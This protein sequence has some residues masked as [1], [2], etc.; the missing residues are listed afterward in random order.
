MEI[1]DVVR[2]AKKEGVQ[3]VEFLYVDNSG[4]ARGKVTHVDHLK[5]RM[6]S[7]IGLTPA[8]M[9]MNVFDHL[10]PIPEMTAVGEVRLMPDP[11]SFRVLPYHPKV[12]AVMCDQ[13]SL[14]HE[15]WAAC[16][17]SFLK[18]IIRQAENMGIT[19]RATYE[20]EFTLARLNEE[21]KH[22]PI[23]ESLCFSAAG[24]VAGN[25]VIL[26]IVSALKDQGI[27]PEQYYPE[28]GFG[29]HELSI[30]ATDLLTAADNQVIFRETVK[31]IARQHG[32]IA[33]F[34]PKPFVDQAGNGGHIHFSIWDKESSKN[35]FWDADDPLKLSEIGYQFAAGVLHHLKG[36]VALTCAS[37]NSY[38]RLQPGSWSSAYAA[39][40]KDNR[41]AALR[42]AS[43][44]WGN[45]EKSMNIELKASDSTANPYLA[46]GAMIASGLDGV[47]NKW[48]PGDY[49]DVD[50]G[51]LTDEERARLG[52]KKL[53]SSLLEALE[54]LRTDSFFADTL[55]DLLF[56]SYTAVKKSE[57][58]MFAR[59]DVPFEL[60]Y[61][62]AKY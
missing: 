14:N 13:I 34:A 51:T 31:A 33:S 35:L 27:Q 22:V 7:G 32:I 21:G 57:Y 11:E 1:D 56:R 44:F 37:V 26:D 61:H 60:N 45:E 28:L 10:Q 29:Q 24:M 19:V 39:F 30:S 50:P 42:I 18:S 23:D 3:L 49:V 12:A 15:P 4:I 43:T 41:E 9:A 2:L 46:L 48:H 40:G 52:I 54:A 62:F 8:M 17:R 38:R 16:P 53:P 55:G 59:H 6:I 25:P 20:D 36:L 5:G 58:D 47:K